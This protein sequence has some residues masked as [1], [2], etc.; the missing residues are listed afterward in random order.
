MSVKLF[1]EHL[2][3]LGEITPGQLTDALARMREHNVRLG[4][5]AMDAGFLSR[6]A[7]YSINRKQSHIDRLFGHL[8]VDLRLMSQD[9]LEELTLF[10]REQNKTLSGMLHSMGLMPA[11][12][13]TELWRQFEFEQ[14]HHRISDHSLPRSLADSETAACLI[15]L[16][17]KLCLRLAQV[18]IRMAAPVPSI[19]S[20]QYPFRAS[21][22]LEAGSSI[23]V[24][25]A[26]DRALAAQLC[27]GACGFELDNILDLPDTLLRDGVAEFLNVLAGSAIGQ[28]ETR[29]HAVH[30]APPRFEVREKR[31]HAFQLACSLG[32]G[33][34]YLWS[35]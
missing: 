31:T 2:V 13:L 17:P 24:G 8:A 6:E 27:G 25:V 30:L 35:E 20:A 22:H 28:L 3:Q 9:Q 21:V 33:A 26:T 1:G 15:D 5:L 4:S 23:V 19:A 18:A 11:E 34:F 10:Q 14:A 12:R 16:F 32:Q 7:T 29:G